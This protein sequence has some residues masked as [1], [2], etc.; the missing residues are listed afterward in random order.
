MEELISMAR[1]FLRTGPGPRIVRGRADL[2]G[3]Y[4]DGRPLKI[5]SVSGPVAEQY[6]RIL[7][8]SSGGLRNSSGKGSHFSYWELAQVFLIVR[9]L[10]RHCLMHE[11]EQILIHILSNEKWPA[12]ADH[13]SWRRGQ[14]SNLRY[15]CAYTTFPR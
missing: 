11:P 2:C 13:F 10:G 8:G 6:D 12:D 3:H 15:T 14:D 5:D 4:Y 1:A 7:V 9:Q